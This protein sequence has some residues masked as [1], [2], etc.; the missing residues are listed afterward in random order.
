IIFRQNIHDNIVA[1]YL[2]M[3]IL[4]PGHWVV[5]HGSK[6]VAVGHAP[7]PFS[8]HPGTVSYRH[9]VILTPIRYMI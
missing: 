8:F 2:N 6:R 9:I 7:P 3:L 1:F 5:T 4:F